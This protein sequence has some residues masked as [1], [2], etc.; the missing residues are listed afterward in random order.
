MEEILASIRK[1]IDEDTRFVANAGPADNVSVDEDVVPEPANQLA[2]DVLGMARGNRA[3][4]VAE[5]VRRTTTPPLSLVADESPDVLRPAFGQVRD[6]RPTARPVSRPD[7]VEASGFES[8]DAALLR[9]SGD[10][11]AVLAEES[12]ADMALEHYGHNTHRLAAEQVAED[13]TYDHDTRQD[14]V[15]FR[16]TD[17]DAVV[18]AAFDKLATQLAENRRRTT[19]T[20]ED[21]AKD[22]MRPMIKEWLDEN[23]FGIVERLVQAEIERVTRRQ[24]F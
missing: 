15:A 4:T 23:L 3:G 12:E 16:L 9:A 1:A 17:L 21:L 8:E 10:A 18:S 11:G 24:G 20:L 14:D 19:P 2:E 6:E 13:A 22:L 5:G 7:Q